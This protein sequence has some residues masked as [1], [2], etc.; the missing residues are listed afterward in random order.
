MSHRIRNSLTLF[1]GIL[2]FMFG[3]LKFFQPIHGW[4]DV[5]IQQSNLPHQAILLGKLGE[6]A[7][8]ILFLSR[9]LRRSLNDR[10]NDLLILIACASLS[11]EMGVAIYVHMQPG[12]PPGVLPLGIKPP[13]IPGFVFFLGMLTAVA[14]WTE[15]QRD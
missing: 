9:W 13:V 7:T 4:F 10:Q 5:Q 14:A 8:G 11:V 15:R 12:V 6:M 3:F 2:M 1:L